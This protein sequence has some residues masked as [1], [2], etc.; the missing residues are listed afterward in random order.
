MSPPDG[1]PFF[2]PCRAAAKIKERSLAD[3]HKCNGLF[4]DSD[5]NGVFALAWSGSGTGTG[6]NGLHGFK[7]LKNGSGTHFS[8]PENVPCDEY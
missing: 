6:K 8:G 4:T 2:C 1:F 7:D 5:T 3:S